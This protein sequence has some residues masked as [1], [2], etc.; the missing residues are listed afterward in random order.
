MTTT[1][2]GRWLAA[3][4]VA[5]ITAA[6]PVAAQTSAANVAG[7]WSVTWDAGVRSQDDRVIEVVQR[8]TGRLVLTARGDSLSGTW[9]GTPTTPSV[10]IAGSVRNG[11]ITLDTT[12]RAITDEGRTYT[13][14]LRLE[15]RLERDRLLGVIF[16][17]LTE[18]DRP[19]PAR[20]FEG[21][22]N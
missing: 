22:R 9:Q 19:V 14:R 2:P 18:G 12:P 15:G 16:L 8:A 17:R 10:A 6:A 7:S 11:L 13:L 20:R 3:T 21:R 1:G 5:T 4:I